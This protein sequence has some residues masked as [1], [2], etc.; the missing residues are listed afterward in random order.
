[1]AAIHEATVTEWQD[2]HLGESPSYPSP[3]T[4]ATTSAIFG[5]VS[6]DHSF[7]LEPTFEHVVIYL[8][9]S[10]HLSFEDYVSLLASSP[11][12]N[13]LWAAMS[14]LKSVDFSPL[15][16]YDAKYNLQQSIPAHKVGLFL[17]CAIHYNFN[18]STII[19]Y[20]GGNFT[21]A[22]RDID[23]AVECLR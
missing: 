13:T 14:Q 10:F 5:N 8:L 21:A 16:H 6:R 19:R 18:V 15:C 2:K 17:A 23:S 11:L 20:I 9:K 1:M 12:F 4:L 3:S 22:H 7:L